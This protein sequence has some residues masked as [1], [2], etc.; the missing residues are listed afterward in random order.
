MRI[1]VW[2][3]SAIWALLSLT[4]ICIGVIAVLLATVGWE[5]L[6]ASDV[7]RTLRL[8]RGALPAARPIHPNRKPSQPPTMAKATRITLARLQ[9]RPVSRR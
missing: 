8:A 2:A 4:A 5:R 9:P 6:R 3:G 7:R 1:P